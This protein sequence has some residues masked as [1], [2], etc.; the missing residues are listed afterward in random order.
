MSVCHS[1][2]GRARS[3]NRGL[4]GFFFGR[5]RLFS[6]RFSACSAWRT[7]SGLA[8]MKN[9]RRRMWE[10]RQLPCSGLCRFSS[11]AFAFTAALT[12]GVPGAIRRDC[13]PASPCAR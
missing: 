4:A 10:I 3:K 5:R 1:W 12:F 11:T 9:I 7:V 2:L 13:S 8:C 6:T